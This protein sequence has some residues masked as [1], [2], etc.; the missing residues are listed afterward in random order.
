MTSPSW[1]CDSHDRTITIHTKQWEH[2][3]CDK[4]KLWLKKSILSCSGPW[5][6]N[7][8]ISECGKKIKM[9]SI[10][11]VKIVRNIFRYDIITTCFYRLQQWRNGIRQVSKHFP[12]SKFLWW[13]TP[14]SELVKT[15]V[16]MKTISL[17][18]WGPG[19]QPDIVGVSRNNHFL[20]D[21]RP[22]VPPRQGRI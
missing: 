8:L 16:K 4:R 1:S 15:D 5:L 22:P 21:P 20:S 13:T 3:T 9:T 11:P 6:Q 12:F 19:P 2:C 18:F 7:I 10:T 17:E 14:N